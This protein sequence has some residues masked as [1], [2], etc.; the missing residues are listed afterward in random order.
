MRSLW[1]SAVIVL[2]FLS[3]INRYWTTFETLAEIERDCKER[4]LN[5]AWQTGLCFILLFTT[6]NYNVVKHKRGFLITSYKIVSQSFFNIIKWTE[7][8]AICEAWNS[9]IH[10]CCCLSDKSWAS[11]FT[12][13]SNAS[14]ASLSSI[15]PISVSTYFALIPR[16]VNTPELFKYNYFAIVGSDI[17]SSVQLDRY[18]PQI[19]TDIT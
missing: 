9:Y 12:T 13:T 6:I 16:D 18:S 19:P 15:S 10:N 11:V 7:S 8:R 4:Q 2:N 17:T 3:K 14:K 5:Y 1:C